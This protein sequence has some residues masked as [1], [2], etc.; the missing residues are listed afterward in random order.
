MMHVVLLFTQFSFTPTPFHYILTMAHTIIVTTTRSEKVVNQKVFVLNRKHARK[1]MPKKVVLLFLVLERFIF[2]YIYAVRKSV[3]SYSTSC[4]FWGNHDFSSSWGSHSVIWLASFKYSIVFNAW[5]S[6]TYYYYE[7]ILFYESGHHL[8]CFVFI[9][10]TR[11][12]LFAFHETICFYL[13]I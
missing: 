11:V 7:I 2:W 13:A 3:S 1:K 10:K 12:V 4:I 9:C 6:L 5:L 8:E